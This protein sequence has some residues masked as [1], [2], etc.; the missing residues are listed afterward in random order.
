MESA[1]L[2][3]RYIRSYANGI[4][5]PHRS[6]KTAYH[7]QGPCL[8]EVT[9]AGRAGEGL[10]HRVTVSLGRSDDLVRGTYRIRLDVE[11]AV[12]FSRLVLFQIGADTYSSTG[13]RKMAI[14][15]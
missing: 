1:R 9:Y 4:R 7:R 6:V 15:D 5:V 10:N 3:R 11:K 2:E 13:E 14:G 12:D 8:T